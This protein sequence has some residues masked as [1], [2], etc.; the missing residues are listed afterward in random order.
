MYFFTII[1]GLVHIVRTLFSALG[2]AIQ[3]EFAFPNMVIKLGL[4]SRSIYLVTTI[5]EPS[6][7][8]LCNS[9]SPPSCGSISRFRFVWARAV[10][11]HSMAQIFVEVHSIE[12]AKLD[13]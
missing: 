8:W 13:Q 3:R 1:I 12:V 11:F 6:V 10:H 5:G 9:P 7:R 2:T 4:G